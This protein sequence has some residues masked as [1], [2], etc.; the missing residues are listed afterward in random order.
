MSGV[1]REID[2]ESVAAYLRDL[3]GVEDVHDLHVWGLSTTDV[4]LTAHLV[5]P[6]PRDD[7]L[8]V[9]RVARELQDRFD[10]DHV[11]LQW[12]RRKLSDCWDGACDSKIVQPA[13]EGEQNR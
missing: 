1:P 11:T 5:K 8:L 12:E 4:A 7:D 10:I 6:D 13:E 3:S 2:M 9:E